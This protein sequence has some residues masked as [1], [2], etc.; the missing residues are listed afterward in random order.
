MT[1]HAVISHS[2]VTNTELITLIRNLNSSEKMDFVFVAPTHLLSTHLGFNGWIS[3]SQ[4]YKRL[5]GQNI[6]PISRCHAPVTEGWWGIELLP[7]DLVT[8]QHQAGDWGM[9]ITG[10]GGE[11]RGLGAA[12]QA[13]LATQSVW[14][15]KISNSFIVPCDVFQASCDHYR[16]WTFC[17]WVFI[18]Q[19]FIPTHYP[20]SIDSCTL[21]R[22]RFRR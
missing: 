3:N 8:G 12:T 21:D 14:W 13:S 19:L 6:T 11:I 15:Q 4:H 10:A 16:F 1:N 9:V 2:I 18:I 7:G 17:I 22:G 20:S 5:F